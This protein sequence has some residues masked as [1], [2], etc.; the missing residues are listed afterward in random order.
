MVIKKQGNIIKVTVASGETTIIDAKDEWIIKKFPCWGIT[1]TKSK[2]VFCERAIETEYSKVRERI[3][4]HR[5]IVHNDLIKQCQAEQV[6]HIDRDRL[7]NRRN[8]LR[9]CTA[10]Q[11]AANRSAK[12]GKRFKGVF[13]RKYLKTRPFV[14]YVDSKSRGNRKRQYLGYY[15]TAEEAARA[16]DCAA[17]EIWGEFAFLNFP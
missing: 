6:D 17:K 1:G 12:E 4:L 14:S 13:H 5:L 7:N 3:Y 8:N 16:Y 11:N 9:I 2:Y 10:I 15:D